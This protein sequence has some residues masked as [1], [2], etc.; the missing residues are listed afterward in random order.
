VPVEIAAA[1]VALIPSFRGGAA[2]IT[3]EL[4]RVSD[5]AGK[6]SGSRFGR[7]FAS[8]SMAPLRAFGAAAVGLF[9]LDKIAGFLSSTVEQA[10][11]LAE[12]GNKISTIFGDA[13]GIVNAFA[14]GG[15]RELGQSRLEVLNA[16][17]TFGVYGKAA[18]LAGKA[19][20]DFSTELV[21]LGHRSGQ[22]LQHFAGAG[23]RGDRRRATWGVGA[24]PRLRR[25]ARRRHAAQRGAAARVDQDHQAGVDAAAAGAGR[26]S[27]DHEANHRGARRLR[28]SLG[29]VG[30]PAAHPGRAVDRPESPARRPAAAGLGAGRAVEQ[31]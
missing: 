7:V 17:A 19:N 5:D 24:D 16:A 25:P 4:T 18:G 23:D 6:K 28:Q 13:T 1:Y 26:P 20:A 11:D 29:W 12:A 9:A 8:A 2:A 30:Q 14:A 21:K 10:S 27:G 22:L 3:K 15:A 31:R